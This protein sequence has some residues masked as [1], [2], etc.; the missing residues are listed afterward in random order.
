VTT[1][2]LFEEIARL[3]DRCA[4]LSARLAELDALHARVNELLDAAGVPADPDPDRSGEP[5]VARRLELVLDVW[6]QARALM[7]DY[8]RGAG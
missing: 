3:R 6:G 4:V 1:A 2:A 8:A 7:H 5:A